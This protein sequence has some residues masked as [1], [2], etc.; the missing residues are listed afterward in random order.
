MDASKSQKIAGRRF[1]NGNY[2]LS[3]K[4]Y[5]AAR[6]EFSVALK[7]YE[8]LGSYKE[9]SETLNNIGITFIKDGKAADAKENFESS[10]LIKKE[11]PNGSK[12]SLFNTIYN[13]L[14]VGSVMDVDD[15]EKYFIEFRSLGEELGGEFMDIVVKEQPVYDRIVEARVK[16]LQIKQE[17]ELART[18]AAGALEHLIRSGLPCMVRVRFL[19]HGFAIDIN[20][21]F[22]FK[23]HGK[24][25]RI[26]SIKPIEQNI[27]DSLVEPVSMGEME[28]EAG[29]DTVRR[30]IE[31]AS[32][33]GDRILEVCPAGVEEEAFDHVKK[34]MKAIAIVREDLSLSISKKYF[35][36]RSLEVINAFGDPVEA[37][38]VVSTKPVVPLTLTTEDAMLV[39]MLLS[40][41]EDVLYKSLLLNAKRLLDEE[42]Y[43]LCV[44]DS[45]LGMESFL[46][47]LFKRTFPES[48]LN[49]YNSISGVTLYDRLKLLKKLISGVHDSEGKMELYLGDIGRDL[50]D[51]LKYYDNI[52]KNGSDDIRAYEAGKSLK[53]VNRVIYNLKSLYGI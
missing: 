14:G 8:R 26:I 4:K 9:M 30:S 39:N 5:P 6:K 46:D 2:L 31:A 20:E 19:L 33:E 32:S 27:D 36:V 24:H 23:E 48:D 35:A 18:S 25:V 42:H 51:I 41:G 49:E 15:Y 3:M 22:M 37:Y 40:S 43:D 10:Y 13:L 44:L 17:E 16:E 52:L 21:P 34:F 38:H 12:E 11:H 47:V 28:F 29:Y 1:Q 45:I 7:I 50:D 53:T